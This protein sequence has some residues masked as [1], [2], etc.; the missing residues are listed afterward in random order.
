MSDEPDRRLRDALRGAD[1]PA[2]PD[3]LREVLRAIPGAPSPSRSRRAWLPGI[4]ALAAVVALAVV[5]AL[6]SVGLGR[7]APAVSSA[8]PSASHS[9]ASPASSV[10]PSSMVQMNAGQRV[11]TAEELA[12]VLAQDRPSMLGKP[13]LVNASITPGPE[14]PCST[15]P[16]GCPM[17]TLAGTSELVVATTYTMSLLADATPSTSVMAMRVLPEGLEFLGW[18]GRAGAGDFVATVDELRTTAASSQT[19]LV[20]F[21]VS[22]W[23]VATPVLK[24]LAIPSVTPGSLFEGCERAWLTPS[25]EQPTVVTPTSMTV[26]PPPD[27]VPVQYGAYQEF[28]PGGSSAARMPQPRF[29]TY[30]VRLV[31]DTPAGANAPRGWQ[32]V[33]R[34]DAAATAP[35]PAPTP[36]ADTVHVY[37]PTEFESTLIADRARLVGHVVL[38]DAGVTAEPVGDSCDVVPAT[39]ASGLCAFG[40]LGGT[41]EAVWASPYTV[42]LAAGLMSGPVISGTLALRVLP[43]GVE[44]LGQT[45]NAANTAGHEAALGDLASEQSTRQPLTTYIVSAWLGT[46]GPLPC[47]SVPGS[48][49]PAD[50]PFGSGC[51]GSWLAPTA[52]QTGYS[53]PEGS[54]P[55]QFGA[56]Q[57][58][59]PGASVD[60]RDPKFGTYLVRLVVDTRQ[61]SDGARGWQVIARLSP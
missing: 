56:Y 7:L 9:V 19:G 39:P 10:G 22:A 46:T 59:A 15:P 44:F 54:V 20:T 41:S 5:V 13:V 12:A 17:G 37:T 33:A 28:A 29:G 24:C 52:T 3:A 26:I 38:V 14:G 53:R 43:S 21:I 47:P 6:V 4:S 8:S 25:A 40:Q 30:L 16:P 11:Y 60:T 61:G 2:A 48:P 32:V 23:L 51:P 18:M 1:L 49:P 50:T 57:D 58:F 35:T 31:N 27:G 45:G 42:K 55:V 36:P 34:L